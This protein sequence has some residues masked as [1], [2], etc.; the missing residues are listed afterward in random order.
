M[1]SATP[2]VLHTICGLPMLGHVLAVADGLDSTLTTVVLSP[3]TL[4][5]V[6]KRF[7]T[8]YAYVSQAE[9]LGTGHAVLQAR[10][11]L[12]GQCDEVLVLYGDTPLLRESTARALV[13]LRREQGALAGLISFQANPPTG[14]GR[15]L[16]DSNGQVSGLVEERDATA[17]QRIIT[18]VNSGV[19]CFKAGLLWERSGTLPRNPSNGE[20][21]LTDLVAMAV[22]EQGPG[23]V[24]ALQS[25]DAREAWGVNDRSQLAQAE[26]VMRERLLGTLMRD[27]VTI[28][29][30]AATY[31]DAGVTIGRDTIV[32]PGA[33]L[34]GTTRVGQG[35]EIGPH[36]TLI[37]TQVGNHSRIRHALIEQST[38]PSE[39]TI[40]PFA[41]VVGEQQR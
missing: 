26:T 37:D 25:P 22:A 13:Q 33:I 39:T 9:R 20:Y 32:W 18:E 16:R 5:Q 11:T 28:V 19:M 35:C 41:H 36:T 21:Y 27:G 23:A 31:V 2:K 29:D 40:G 30:P 15:V 3:N 34:R 17:A 38:I 4:E 8:R 6:R 10:T 14:Y 1:R 24:V 7:G 12:A